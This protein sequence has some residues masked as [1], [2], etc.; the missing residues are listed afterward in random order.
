MSHSSVTRQQPKKAS[1]YG[2][3]SRD[4][5][6]ASERPCGMPNAPN[7]API[8]LTATNL[9]AYMPLYTRDEPPARESARGHTVARARPERTSRA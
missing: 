3:R 2:W 6:A 7:D 8:S 1:T 5:S 9:P 4:S